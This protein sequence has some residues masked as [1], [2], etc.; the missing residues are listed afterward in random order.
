[1]PQIQNRQL[2]SDKSSRYDNIPE[3]HPGEQ[4]YV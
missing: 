4:D 2:Y 3:L 1:M